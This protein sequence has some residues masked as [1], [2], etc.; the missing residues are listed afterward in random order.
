[1]KLKSITNKNSVMGAK[2]T[3]KVTDLTTAKTDGSKAQ[4]STAQ[5]V[6]A[7]SKGGKVESKGADK[8]KGTGKVKKVRKVEVRAKYTGLTGNVVLF[9][10]GSKGNA[11]RL[12]NVDNNGFAKLTQNNVGLRYD[13]ANIDLLNIGKMDKQ[14]KLELGNYIAGRGNSVSVKAITIAQ[15]ES[16]AKRKVTIERHN[17]KEATLRTL[18]K[19]DSQYVAS[20]EK[21]KGGNHYF[22]LETVKI[23]GVNEKHYGALAKG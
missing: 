12:A 18:A 7:N 11:F 8:A 15:A 3:G 16:M 13:G 19:I 1:M 10:E 23:K 6:K 14:S 20:I 5:T 17:G 22:Q 21:L 2:S 9:I 4:A